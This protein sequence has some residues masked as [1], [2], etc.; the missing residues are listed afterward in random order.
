MGKSPN[1]SFQCTF[2]AFTSCFNYLSSLFWCTVISLEVWASLHIENRRVTPNKIILVHCVC[3]GI[4]LI[5]T[6]LPLT[7]NTYG[8]TNE[9]APWCFIGTRAGSPSWGI[10]VWDLCSFFIWLWLVLILNMWLITSIIYRLKT[11][12]NTN[13]IVN[14]QVANLCLYP[15]VAILC[16]TPATIIDVFA[17]TERGTH[18][19]Y[20]YNAY[21]FSDLM[22]ASQGF[23]F[24][25]I[26]FYIN[27][28]IRK[29]WKLLL[30]RRCCRFCLRGGDPD[31]QSESPDMHES[32]DISDGTNTTESMYVLEDSFNS[33]FFQSI[34][35]NSNSIATGSGSGSS[36]EMPS[37]AASPSVSRP[38][39][40]SSLPQLD[41]NKAGGRG[42]EAEQGRAESRVRSRVMTVDSIYYN[43]NTNYSVQASD[44]KAHLTGKS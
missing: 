44:K 39:A 9:D 41:A 15:I 35:S 42:S 18:T 2:Q 30:A 10:L 21:L 28:S 6:L 31:R 8:K 5:V 17:R 1:G 36:V 34:S 38:I 27:P 33:L 11:I 14:W 32:L 25:I 4:P 19:A 37:L 3:W 12:T 26:F 40:R 20:F 16:W 7:T 43:S 23:L 29:K 24:P 13:Q 22:S